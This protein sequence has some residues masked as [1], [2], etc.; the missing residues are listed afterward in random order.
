[1]FLHEGWLHI[2]VNMLFL[3]VF[4]NNVEDRLG[5]AWFVLLYACGGIAAMLLQLAFAPDSTVPTVGASGAISAVLGA[6]LVLFPRARITTL[7]LF[8]V[9]APVWLPAWV[10]LGGW[11]LL[12]LFS[13]AG[14]LGAQVNGGVAYWAHVGGFAFGVA[15]TWLFFR[16][17]REARPILPP[18]PRPDLP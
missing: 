5:R 1:M 7:I 16:D 18:P 15:L 2:A 12:Q 8:F 14:G 9:I 6:Y 3:W 10:A 13:G 4:G 17:R 11:F